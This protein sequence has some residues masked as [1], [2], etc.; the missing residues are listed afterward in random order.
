MKESVTPAVSRRSRTCSMKVSDSFFGW[1]YQ[2]PVKGRTSARRPRRSR[3][4]TS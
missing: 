3:S 2:S 4:S 1:V